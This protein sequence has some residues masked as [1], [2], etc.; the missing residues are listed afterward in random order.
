MQGVVR[1]GYFIV[2]IPAFVLL[3]SC[4]VQ[5]QRQGFDA[6]TTATLWSWDSIKTRSAPDSASPVT[7]ELPPGLSLTGRERADGWVAL[8]ADDGGTLG[9]VLR[10]E[11]HDRPLP[12]AH[13][14]LSQAT[15]VVKLLLGDSA[16][17]EPATEAHHIGGGMFQVRGSTA[18]SAEA[19][20]LAY[21]L[22]LEYDSGG[23]W[24]ARDLS[25][26]STVH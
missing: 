24:V 20:A 10:R 7:D 3:I 11:L 2:T 16:I 4:R 21:T 26:Y 22:L 1:S 25:T 9:Y 19:P 14:V 13:Q 8:L 6:T 17:T 23:N 18:G 5:E 15:E 12:E